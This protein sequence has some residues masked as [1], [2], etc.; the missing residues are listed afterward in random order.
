MFGVW[1]WLVW[2]VD[3]AA[4][5]LDK[6]TADRLC[7]AA[8]AGLKREA[9]AHYAGI[10]PSTLYRWINFGREGRPV[11]AEFYK[12]LEL[13]RAKAQRR[14]LD[15]IENAAMSSWQAAAWILERS[16]GW[17][18]D[19]TPPVQITIDADNLDVQALIGEYKQHLSGLIDGPVIDLDED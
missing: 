17:S 1:L 16:F 12:R 6:E 14:L 18:K 4:L 7:E 19:Q 13:S 2:V 5:K 15:T 11:Y 3:M 9:C 10:D 8:E